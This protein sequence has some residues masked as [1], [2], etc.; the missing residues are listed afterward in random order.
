MRQV[1]R[2][3][4]EEAAVVLELL[5]PKKAHEEP[6]QDRRDEHET[7]EKTAWEEG[8]QGERS[9]AEPVQATRHPAGQRQDRRRGGCHVPASAPRELSTIYVRRGGAG[10]KG[11]GPPGVKER[12]A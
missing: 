7:D 10:G 6:R 9:V 2:Q 3:P 4:D 12:G 8:Q 1:V 5:N 11:P